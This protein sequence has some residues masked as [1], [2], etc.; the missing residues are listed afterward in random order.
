[1]LTVQKMDRFF[2]FQFKK[3]TKKSMIEGIKI[4]KTK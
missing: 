2:I 1:M 3:F 4:R